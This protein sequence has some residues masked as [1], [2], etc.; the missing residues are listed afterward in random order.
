MLKE[1]AALGTV[2]GIFNLAVVLKDALLENQNQDMFRESFAPKALATIHLDEVSRELCPGLKDFVVFS[3]VSCGRGNSGQT[4]YGMANSVMERICEKRHS[5][6]YPA[7]AIQ[8]G[9]IGEVSYKTIILEIIKVGLFKVGLVA[10]L[11][12]EQFE[13]EIGG[14]LQQKI[15]SCLKVLDLFLRQNSPVVGSMVVAEKRSG[16]GF[17]NNAVD[18]VANILGSIQ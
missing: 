18:A 15:S 12:E 16:A 14:T 7:L 4:N 6:G 2:E 9:A 13:M 3:S 17:A 10:E 1:A 11:Q 8:W 5:E